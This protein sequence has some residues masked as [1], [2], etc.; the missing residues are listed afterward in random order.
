MKNSITKKRVENAIKH[1]MKK[2]TQNNQINQNQFH[3]FEASNAFVTD[4]QYYEIFIIV[5]IFF[6]SLLIIRC[7]HS[8]F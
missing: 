1:A 5:I 7:N 4:Q 2:K 8:G 3:S 6:L